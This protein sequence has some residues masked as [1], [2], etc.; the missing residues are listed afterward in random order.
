[1][2]QTPL[3][4]GASDH[5]LIRGGVAGRLRLR[6]LARIMWPTTRELLARVGVPEDARCLD[7]GCG[8]GDV[9]IPLARLAPRGQVVGT[10]VDETSSSWPGP[11]RAPPGSRTSSSGW[12]TSPSRPDGPSGSISCMPGSCS[13][14]WPTRRSLWLASSL[15]SSPGACWWS[16]TSTARGILLP[17][18]G[19]LPALRRAVH[20]RRPGPGRGS[21]GRATAA[22]PAGGGRPGR[23]RHERRPAGRLPGRGED[24]RAD[25]PGGDRRRRRR[26]R[27]GNGGGA[28]PVARRW[29]PSTAARTASSPR[30]TRGWRPGAGGWGA[31]RRGSSRT[32]LAGG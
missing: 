15:G 26:R 22:R 27:P 4:D 3:D 31:G 16:R 18:V 21:R 13:P 30:W 11:R 29:S 12:R 8:G 7:V 17:G 24:H 28:G 25:D 6:V 2:T 5:Y 14:A 1:M 32:A 20:H 9:T 19:G 10:D 23:S